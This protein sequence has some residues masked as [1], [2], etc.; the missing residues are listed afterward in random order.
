MFTPGLAI[1]YLA[2]ILRLRHVCSGY[3]SR[4]WRKSRFLEHSIGRW[5]RAGAWALERHRS[6]PSTSPWRQ[7]DNIDRASRALA[8][9]VPPGVPKSY[10]A[11]A[12]HGIVPR[13]TLHH[14]ACGR[15]SIEA[16]AQGQQYLKLYKEAQTFYFK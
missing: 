15:P 11:L 8:Q 2:T 7:Q 13:S 16:K 12:D 4:V 6:S 9:D 14:R 3:W 1:F 10:R 5:Q